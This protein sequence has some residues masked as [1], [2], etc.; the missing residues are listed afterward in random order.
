MK[1]IPAIDWR[2]VDL[3]IDMAIEEDLGETGDV[4][5]LSVV[6]ASIQAKAVLRCKEEGMVMAG[7]EV[8]ERVFRRL[9]PECTYTVFKE[10]GAVCQYGDIIAVNISTFADIIFIRKN[11]HRYCFFFKVLRNAETAVVKFK[12]FVCHTVTKAP[13]TRDTVAD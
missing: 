12:Q 9:D 3:L 8:A 6:P 13:D 5:S 2:R 1:N 7:Q 4:T 10:D 11:R